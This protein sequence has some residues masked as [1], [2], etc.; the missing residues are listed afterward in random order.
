MLSRGIIEMKRHYQSA[1]HLRLEQPYCDRY[2]LEAVRRMDARL[3]YGE[4]LAAEREAYKICEVPETDHK[5]PSYYDV[6][7][8][9]PFMFAG[10]EDCV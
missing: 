5:R 3:L 9:K 7:E 4:C 10:R 1:G 6:V 2:F 8:G